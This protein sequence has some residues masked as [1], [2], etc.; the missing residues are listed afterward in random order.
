M[1]R[2]TGSV[3]RR[4]RMWVR[5]RLALTAITKSGGVRSAQA[6]KVAGSGSR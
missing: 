2:L 6:A 5:K 1:R 4:R 3:S